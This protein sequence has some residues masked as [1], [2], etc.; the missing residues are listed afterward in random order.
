MLN[1]FQ[2]LSASFA[3]AEKWTLKRVQGDDNCL[4]WANMAERQATAG[5][6]SGGSSKLRNLRLWRSSPSRLSR[7]SA[8]MPMRKC[9]LIEVS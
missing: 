1:L 8:S 4:G 2:H 9:W 6:L 3:R 5:H 7:P